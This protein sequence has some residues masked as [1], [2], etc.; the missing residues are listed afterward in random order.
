MISWQS[1]VAAM[2]KHKLCPD[3]TSPR[4]YGSTEGHVIDPRQMTM[5][6]KED[7]TKINIAET[8][9]FG[10]IQK[11]AIWFQQHWVWELFACSM[12][13][14]SL[15]AITIIL[16]RYDRKPTPEWPR[17]ITI[18]SALALMTTTMKGS[19]IF[20]V[21]E[22]TFPAFV[23]HKNILPRSCRNLTVEMVLVYAGSSVERLWGNRLS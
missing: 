9:S 22:G 4:L 6:G 8:H 20:T 10:K 5:F 15:M 14:L 3:A 12:S 11:Y 1:I 21:S 17:S 16:A 19:I 2:A 23:W 13:I 18:N 7:D